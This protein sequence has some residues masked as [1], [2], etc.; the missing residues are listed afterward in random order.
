[1][2]NT[3]LGTPA[4]RLRRL[5]GLAALVNDAETARANQN[6]DQALQRSNLP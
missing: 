3:W 4:M 6:Q 5:A 2:G 1:V